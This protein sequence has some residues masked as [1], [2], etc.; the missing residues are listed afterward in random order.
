MAGANV[1]M[2]NISPENARKSYDLYSGKVSDGG[3]TE[4]A[5]KKLEENLGD[6]GYA[7]DWSRGDY[8][9]QENYV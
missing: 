6:M 1:I 4:E 2:P 5:L 3:E 9:K 8:K 7:V